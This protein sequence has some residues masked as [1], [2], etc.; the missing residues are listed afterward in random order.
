MNER[1]SDERL[2]M[3]LLKKLRLLCGT[4]EAKKIIVQVVIGH[5]KGRRIEALK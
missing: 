2:I 3:L 1:F 4:S 5:R